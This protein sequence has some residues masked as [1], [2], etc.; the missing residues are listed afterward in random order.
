MSNNRGKL[1]ESALFSLQG[2][3]FRYTYRAGNMLT[4][5]FGEDKTHVRHDGTIRV[6][7]R[8]ALHVQSSWRLLKDNSIVLGCDDF[9]IAQNGVTYE[10]FKVDGGFG[11]SIFDSNSTFLNEY[12]E[13]R[14]I[15]VLKIEASDFGD[16]V[17]SMDDNYRLEVMYNS[18]VLDESWRFFEV[19]SEKKH[20]VVFNE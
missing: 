17:I 2:E 3:R 11:K 14:H 5:G 7:A 8:Y 9:Y 15:C 10:E 12:I 16:L 20:F 18:S 19:G 4:M 6:V 1:I 13:H